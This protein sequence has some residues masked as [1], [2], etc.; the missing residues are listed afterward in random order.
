MS[1]KE[2][3]TKAFMKTGEIPN[4]GATRRVARTTDGFLLHR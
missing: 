1:K 4:V 2:R 3:V